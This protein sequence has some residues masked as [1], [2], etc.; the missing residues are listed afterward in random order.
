[1]GELLI[2]FMGPPRED[3]LELQVVSLLRLLLK[4]L[5]CIHSLP[6]SRCTWDLLNLVG[7]GTTDQGIRRDT[8]TTM[9]YRSRCAF[10]LRA[11]G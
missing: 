10:N 4:V 3:F 2:T 7:C 1:M 9:V 8:V 6:G 11:H 5:T